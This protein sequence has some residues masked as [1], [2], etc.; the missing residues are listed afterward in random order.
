MAGFL[1]AEGN[2]TGAPASVEL[3]DPSTG[4]FSVAGNAATLTGVDSAT[5]LN[6]GRGLLSGRVGTFPPLAYGAEL[7]DPAA[8][9]F[10]LVA[11]WPGKLTAAE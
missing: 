11:H 8:G 4:S 1:F 3:Y 10:G 7:Y 9:T 2:F 6:D 5:L